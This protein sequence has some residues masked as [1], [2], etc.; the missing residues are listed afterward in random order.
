MTHYDQVTSKSL[1]E[2]AEWLDVNGQHDDSPW[3]SW[4]NENYCN[5]CESIECSYTESGAHIENLY[6]RRIT[7]ECSYCEL[8]NKCKFFPD[9]TGVL[10]NKDI[11]KLWLKEEAVQ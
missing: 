11:I 2:L 5:R 6:N 1:E 4:F 9:Y 3:M 7:F 8:E 10:D